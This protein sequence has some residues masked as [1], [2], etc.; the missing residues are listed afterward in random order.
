MPA[1]AA[2]AATSYGGSWALVRRMFE[3]GQFKAWTY[4]PLAG[5]CAFSMATILLRRNMKVP[6][7]HTHARALG[8]RHRRRDCCRL[9]TAHRATL[10]LHPCPRP[11][12][13]QVMLAVQGAIGLGTIAAANSVATS[14]IV[15]ERSHS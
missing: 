13:P 7:A 6:G 12:P 10:L 15:R 11:V 3:R 1:A 14:A 2:P 8:E 5:G 9:R 4:V